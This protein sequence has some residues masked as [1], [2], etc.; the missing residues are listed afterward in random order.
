MHH[1]AAVRCAG[2]H[3]CHDSLARNFTKAVAVPVLSLPTRLG[4]GEQLLSEQEGV[5]R[6]VAADA[7]ADGCYH[8]KHHETDR[9]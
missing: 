2:G 8:G 3:A 9:S 1:L 4:L 6:V 5:R 7:S